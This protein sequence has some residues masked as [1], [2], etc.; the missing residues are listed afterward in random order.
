MYCFVFIFL[1]IV[2]FNVPNHKL[3]FTRIQMNVASPPLLL[4]FNFFE[5]DKTRYYREIL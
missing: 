3:N 5:E 2:E 4:S 1:N